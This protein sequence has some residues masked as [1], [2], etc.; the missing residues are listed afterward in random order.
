MELLVKYI[1]FQS[2]YGY[3]HLSSRLT[4]YASIIVSFSFGK[5]FT[6]YF[7]YNNLVLLSLSVHQFFM[8][9]F[10]TVLIV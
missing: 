8:G 3:F 10:Q 7:L 6:V 2:Q 5:H 4:E 1:F 9:Y